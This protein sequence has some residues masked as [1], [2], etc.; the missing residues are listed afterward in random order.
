MKTLITLLI[1]GLAIATSALYAEDLN[2]YS[3]EQS[4]ELEGVTQEANGF[5]VDLK[6]KRP[7][8]QLEPKNTVTT[9]MLSYGYATLPGRD[10]PTFPPCSQVNFTHLPVTTKDVVLS[11]GCLQVPKGV[12]RISY[13]GQLQNEGQTDLIQLWLTIQTVPSGVAKVIPESRI[14]G[15]IRPLTNETGPTNFQVTGEVIVSINKTSLVCLN[16]TTQGRSILT[17]IPALLTP[18]LR[19]P[20]PFYLLAIKIAEV[21]HN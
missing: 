14:Q 9:T 15:N 18:T 2:Q 3:I 7:V 6:L 16:Y 4:I 21:D 12:Y 13:A 8:I 11:N 17:S 10:M 20:L 5:D 19:A 1:S